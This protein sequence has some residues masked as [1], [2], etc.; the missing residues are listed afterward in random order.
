MNYIDKE[1]VLSD[2]T[3]EDII[4]ICAELGS[5]EYKEDSNGILYFSTSICHGGDSPYKLA[6]Y[7]S[8]DDYKYGHF[9]CFTCSDSYNVIEL[10]IRANRLKGK[11]ITWFK[12]L[13]WIVNITGRSDEDYSEERP[14]REKITDWEWIN[15]LDVKRSREIATLSEINENIL[16]LFTYLPYDGWIGEGIIPDVFAE[17]EI[18]YC[19]LR[20]AV[21]IPHRDI[22]SRLIGIRGRNLDPWVVKNVGK[23]T[24]ITVEGKV[25]R[26]NLGQNLYGIH[27]NKN[28]IKRTGKVM[29]VEGEKSVLQCNSF[30]P[31]NSFALATCGSN[32]SR[33][34]VQM[35][36]KVLGVD[37]VILAYDREYEDPQSFEAELYKNKLLKKV[38]PFINFCRVSLL[39]D[40]DNL[41]PYKGSPT[42]CGKEV[43][44][45]LLD[46][47]IPVTVKDV[48]EALEKGI[49]YGE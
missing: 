13:S 48:N 4:K 18:S 40:S 9:H 14:L 11:T 39:M 3:K 29:L 47:K 17:F 46:E 2:L 32:I 10:V 22:N 38:A 31:E 37:E 49:K 44:E 30:Y 28:T 7:P 35:V 36:L 8:Q 33:T 23:Y 45:Q 5:E 34:Q 20:D 25:L 43:L 27:I 15:H 24:P 26:H 16:E 12:A 42:D 19:P 1:K 6:Y 41:L 21:I